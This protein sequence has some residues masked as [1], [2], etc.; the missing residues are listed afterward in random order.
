M[1]RRP[2]DRVRPAAELV[3]PG[4]YDDQGRRSALTPACLPLQVVERAGAATADGASR[5]AWQNQLI[6]GDNLLAMQ[7]LL[8]QYAGQ[9]DLI[10]LDPPY[11]T[12]AAFNCGG[13]GG[14]PGAGPAHTA[15]RDSW[16]P[17]L[18]A[19]L[20]MMSQRLQLMRQLLSDRGS[21]MLHADWRV[22]SHL[23]L[24]LDEIFGPD[25]LVNEIAWCYGGGG[26]PRRRYPRKHDTIWWYARGKE[27]IFNRQYRP[28]SAG[29]LQRGLT[30][31]KGPRYH[32][33]QEGAGLDDWWHGKP[34]QKILSPTARENLKYPTQKP[35]GLLR[36]VVLGHS[37]PGSLVADFF[38]GAGTT[39]AVAEQHGRRWIGCDQSRR[40]IQVTRKRLLTLEP[41]AAPLELRDHGLGEI[42]RWQRAE[43]DDDPAAVRALVLELHGGIA[44]P[45][46]GQIHGRKADAGVHVAGADAPLGIKQLSQA[47]RHCQE[48]GL[49]RLHALAWEFAPGLEQAA[50]QQLGPGAPAVQLFRLP[51]QLLDRRAVTSGNVRLVPSAQVTVRCVVLPPLAVELELM[52]YT[53]GD[54]ELA[55]SQG[56]AS[57]AGLELVDSWGVA[58]DHHPATAPRLDWVSCRTRRQLVSA[59]TPR[60]RYSAPGRYQLLVKVVDLLGHETLHLQAVQLG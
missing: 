45:D 52:Q 53:P 27:W 49:P 1:V 34:V 11:A 19:Y 5:D 12:G 35:E 3:W 9:I 59:A 38:C 7:S 20:E 48:L 37:D 21:L 30:Q 14:K 58:L 39:L 29:T 13:R 32:L 15:Y 24:L 28:Y 47:A 17:G 18:G 4:K 2:R 43:H 50:A 31:V 41:A 42:Q 10:Y 23:R 55:S 56:A 54:P 51:R 6:R 33:R 46:P 36:R 60:L 25:A 40:A 26:A 22:S 8:P 16:G 57:T 44:S